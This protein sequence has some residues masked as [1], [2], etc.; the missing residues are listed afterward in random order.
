MAENE[1]QGLN[2]VTGARN[3]RIPRLALISGVSST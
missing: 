1:R 2:A 3:S